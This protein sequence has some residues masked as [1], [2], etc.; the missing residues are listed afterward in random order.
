VFWVGPDLM[1]DLGETF[2]TLAPQARQVALLT[3]GGGQARPLA[4]GGTDPHAWLDPTNGIAWANHGAGVL[5]Q[6]DPA[7]AATYRANAAALAESLRA[8]DANLAAQ[9]APVAGR[10][11]VTYHDALGYF[12]DHYGLAVAGAIELGDAT[13]P[14]A[15]QL[16]QVQR[17][18]AGAGAV[19]VFPEAG[20]DPKYI[21]ALTEG[22]AVRIGREQ[23]LEFITLPAGRGQYGVMLQG[24][25]ATLLDCLAQ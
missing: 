20:R 4:E 8:L 18:L 23:D 19:C 25:A 5:A 15:A 12:T 16:D 11:F 22:L 21:A 24:I 13:T 7:N 6:A 3:Q 2:A 9:L 1:P 10:A 14:S 17:V